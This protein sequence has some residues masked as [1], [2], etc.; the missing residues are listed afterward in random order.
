MTWTGNLFF[1]LKVKV[2]KGLLKYA[3]ENF[4]N[5]AV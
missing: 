1:G 3:L 5:N 4:L 2:H